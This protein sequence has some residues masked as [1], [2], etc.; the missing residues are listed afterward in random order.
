MTF[1]MSYDFRLSLSAAKFLARSHASHELATIGRCDAQRSN[2][3]FEGGVSEIR[4]S[5][6]YVRWLLRWRWEFCDRYHVL[7]AS[8]IAAVPE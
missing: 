5:F 2:N 7:D 8:T 6:R 4:M 1:G 3:A